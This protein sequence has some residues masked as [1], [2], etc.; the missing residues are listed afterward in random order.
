LPEALSLDV[1]EWFSSAGVGTFFKRTDVEE[2][3]KVLS[4]G[5]GRVI[6]AYSISARPTGA[7]FRAWSKKEVLDL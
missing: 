2:K 7:R 6:A 1:E 4:K 3:K 5:G